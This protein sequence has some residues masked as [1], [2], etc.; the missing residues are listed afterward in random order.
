MD[1]ISRCNVIN[2]ARLFL[3]NFQ[4]HENWQG[5]DIP[6]GQ[7]H[8]RF[9]SNVRCVTR[10][11]TNLLKLTKMYYQHRILC[12]CSLNKGFQ[13]IFNAFFTE[14]VGGWYWLFCGIYDW[15]WLVMVS[16][17]CLNWPL[18]LGG[19]MKGRKTKCFYPSHYIFTRLYQ[20]IYRRFN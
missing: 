5:M 13:K 2:R 8:L 14:E 16:G 3:I 18:L 4:W 10:T 11:S 9:D 20:Y 1:D 7:L 17:T 19:S 12:I 15:W 6:F